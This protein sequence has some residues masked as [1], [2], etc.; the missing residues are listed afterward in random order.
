MS[1]L[2]S[3]TGSADL[4][5]ADFYDYDLPQSS[6]AQE[7]LADRAAARLLVLD[8]STQ[9]IRHMN[10]RDLPEIL[11]PNDLMIVND[12]QVVPARLHGRRA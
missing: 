4:N 2:I 8:R 5:A 12:S 6:I 9:S 1:I 7:P 10:I 11:S 3:M